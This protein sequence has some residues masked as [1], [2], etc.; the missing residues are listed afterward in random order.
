MKYISVSKIRNYILNDCVLDWLDIYGEKK[1]YIKDTL[2]YSNQFDFTEYICKKGSEFE[3][4]I[5]NIIK[6]NEKEIDIIDINTNYKTAI[7]SDSYLKTINAINKKIPIIIHGMLQ[8]DTKKIYGI[9]DIIIRN[10]YIKKIFDIN[11]E[12]KENSNDYSIIDIK[13]CSLNISKRTNEF[14]NKMYEA[15]ITLYTDLLN[16][17]QKN[18]TKHAYILPR[19]ISNKTTETTKKIKLGYIK[20][21]EE[22]REK[23]E[24]AIEWYREV[25]NE[26]EEWEFDYNS[27]KFERRILPNMK[28]QMSSPWTYA[29]KKIAET[30]GEITSMYGCSNKIKDIAISLNIYT[31]KNPRFIPEVIDKY[32]INDNERE[33]IKTMINQYFEGKI[34]NFEKIKSKEKIE[35]SNIPEFYIDFE[36]VSNINDDF[37]KLPKPGGIDMI[38]MIGCGYTNKRNNK[39]TYRVFRATELNEKEERKIIIQ[40]FKFIGIMKENTTVKMYHWTK[41][42]RTFMNTA[43]KR[44]EDLQQYEKNINY[45]DLHKIFKDNKVIIPNVFNYKLKDVSHGLFN[46]E[47]INTVW[48]NNGIDGL[49]AMVAAFQMINNKRIKGKTQIIRDITRYNEID[50]KVMW[51]MKN[52]EK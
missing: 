43:L 39:W 11:I 41:A 10:D 31:W 44:N 5:I 51:E 13:Y 45:I 37:S 25:K 46:N 19:K 38:F 20:I 21:K 8:D 50:C 27:E 1:G 33:I 52:L 7:Q 48:S 18:K 32:I 30:I 34:L 2:H 26:G 14:M 9:P 28:N 24:K 6:K 35:I 12:I 49:K 29:K 15:Q 16:K 47:K 23:N 40:F 4:R 17:I 42:E 36:T 22:T 3:Q